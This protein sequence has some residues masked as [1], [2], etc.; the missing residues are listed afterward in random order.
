MDGSD[1]FWSDLKSAD[2]IF[3]SVCEGFYWRMMEFP[4]TPNGY[5]GCRECVGEFRS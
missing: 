5:K 4:M 3:S 2:M 1:D